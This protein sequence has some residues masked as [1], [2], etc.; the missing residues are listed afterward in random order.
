[1]K[2]FTI[3]F[4]ML[5]TVF[6]VTAVH[7][8]SD[9]DEEAAIQRLDQT[10]DYHALSQKLTEQ[11]A[12]IACACELSRLCLKNGSTSLAKS[13][14]SNWWKMKSIPQ[15]ILL[16]KATILQRDHHFTE[17]LEEL[18]LLINKNPRHAEAWLMKS[19][20]HAICGDY[21]EA[22]TSAIPLFGMTSPVIASTATANALSLSGKAT[23]SYELLLS[24]L[25]K[26][27]NADSSD[28][29]C[30]AWTVLAEIAVRL[31]KNDEAK[32]H[33]E[34]ALAADPNN[35]YTRA[36]FGEFLIDSGDAIAA[37]RLIRP[38]VSG[39]AE[40]LILA[41]AEKELNKPNRPYSAELKHRFASGELSGS[42]S[43]ARY[44]L[45]I[46]NDPAKAWQIAKSNWD[47][48]QR[49]PADTL[50]ALR[51]AKAAGADATEIKDWL[52]NSGTADVRLSEYSTKN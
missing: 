21:G 8:H 23:E 9:H 37:W 14:L 20:I 27:N 49:E 17:A 44:F 40:T 2:S 11:P 15:E 30:W 33:F 48:L 12:N 41:L 32:S 25:T 29:R 10:K 18:V 45:D 13:A 26:Q 51:A 34:E 39:E 24:R 3:P 43:A 31:G 4:A 46:A 6:L 16:L 1:M 47:A 50:L 38:A 22:Y 28:V 36:T 7:A 19:T 5:I 52:S 35:R 42:R